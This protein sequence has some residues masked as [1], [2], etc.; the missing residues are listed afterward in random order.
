MGEKPKNYSLVYGEDN[1]N[2]LVSSSNVPPTVSKISRLDGIAIAPRHPEQVDLRQ[3]VQRLE[4]LSKENHQAYAID[5]VNKHYYSVFPSTMG[6]YYKVFI[7]YPDEKE[8]YVVR[9][10]RNTLRAVK[11]KLPKKGHLRFFFKQADATH[12]EVESEDATVP[13]YEKGG[14]KQIYC[15]VFPK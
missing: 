10:S 4:G 12:E 15:R 3:V 11:E 5:A 2:M 8:T 14:T 6:P 7:Q 1:G 9:V 13:F